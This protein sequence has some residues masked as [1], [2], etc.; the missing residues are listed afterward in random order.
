MTCSSS[1]VAGEA[2]DRGHDLIAVVGAR[3]AR[4]ARDAGLPA[5]LFAGMARSYAGM[6]FCVR[7]RQAITKIVVMTCSEL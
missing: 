6:V 2:E 7:T 5:W 3:H 4:D 1:R